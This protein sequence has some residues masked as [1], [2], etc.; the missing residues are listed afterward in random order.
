MVEPD[1]PQEQA[2]IDLRVSAPKTEN[3]RNAP[4]VDAK[5]AP[6]IL[7]DGICGL[8][9]TGA[10]LRVVLFTERLNCETN[11]IERVVSA[12]LA[13]PPESANII[14][15]AVGQVLQQLVDQSLIPPLAPVVASDASSD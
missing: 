13:M 15:T 1:R 5:D 7:V 6:E 8:T 2:P 11:T 4:V 14:V 10:V 12:R 3:T 9:V